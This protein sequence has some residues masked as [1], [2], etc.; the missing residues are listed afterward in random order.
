M[1]YAL[2][3]ALVGGA[4]Q[5]SS[6]SKSS[7]GIKSPRGF[8]PIRFA[9]SS[10]INVLSTF[11]PEELGK[12]EISQAEFRRLHRENPG[13]VLRIGQP[14]KK[15]KKDKGRRGLEAFSR[16]VGDPAGAAIAKSRRGGRGGKGD[17]RRYFRVPTSQ[18]FSQ[19]ANKAFSQRIKESDINA[20]R[21]RSSPLYKD[22]F[23]A[24]E[25][26]LGAFGAE[27]D[28]SV[29]ALS[30]RALGAASTRGTLSNPAVSARAVAPIAMARA[31]ARHSAIESARA[32]IRSLSAGGGLRGDFAFSQNQ[33]ASVRGQN[34]SAFSAGLGAQAS[35]QQF[36][37]GIQ[38]DAYGQVGSAFAS[39]LE[40]PPKQ[41]KSVYA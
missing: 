35:A 28:S 1:A 29:E 32:N 6:A 38:S 13:S 4:A 41:T 18:E 14:P 10:R 36:R 15:R 12:Y 3:G 16:S 8:N 31:Q 27:L 20:K 30:D 26:R 17:T 24:A 25:G 33:L 9:A 7:K 40:P 5:Y 21:L 37:A 22:I 2:I 11:F 19:L 34:L 23:A 39:F